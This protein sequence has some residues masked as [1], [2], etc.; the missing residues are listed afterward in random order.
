MECSKDRMEGEMEEGW[1]EEEE[2][3]IG[4]KENRR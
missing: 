3:G 2:D 1:S 4:V